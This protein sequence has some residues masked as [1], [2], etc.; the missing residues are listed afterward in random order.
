MGATN[1]GRPY[2][3]SPISRLV[4]VTRLIKWSLTKTDNICRGQPHELRKKDTPPP[5]DK[6]QPFPLGPGY[7]FNTIEWLETMT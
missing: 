4:C 7:N 3:R 1:E 5:Q 6:S 2:E